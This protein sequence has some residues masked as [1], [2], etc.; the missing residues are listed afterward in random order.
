L[1]KDGDGSKRII[2]Q[3]AFEIP[4]EFASLLYGHQSPA[5]VEEQRRMKVEGG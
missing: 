2:P 5:Y 3:L 1:A 4:P